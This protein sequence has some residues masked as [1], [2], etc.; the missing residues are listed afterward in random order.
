[1][2][3]IYCLLFFVLCSV[4]T[5]AQNNNPTTL[6]INFSA[7]TLDKAL[8]Q[9]KDRS[10]VNIAYD[11][12]GLDV[13]KINIA[14]RS[15]TNAPLTQVVEYLLRNTPFTY[16]QLA[17]GI[18]INR[19]EK[20]VPEKKEEKPT[21]LKG[22]VVDF[23]TSQPLPGATVRVVQ[24]DKAVLT[25]E[26]GFYE[27]RNLPAG[28]YTL[29]VSYVGY[30][31]TQITGVE[32]LNNRIVAFDI[33]MQ[34]GKV[35][36]TVEV[37][38][39]ARKVKAVTHSTDRQLLEEIRSSTGVVS[40][41]SNEFINKT[42]DRNGAEIVKRISGVTVVDDRFIVIRG[43]NERYNL[44]YL[45][46]NVAPSTE[47]FGKAFAYDLLPSSVIDKILVYKSPVADLV[48]D[49]GGA[50]LKVY[51]KNTMP[52]KHLDVG[53]QLGHRPGSTN[54][55]INSY[56]GG[57]YDFLGF[58]DGTRRLPAFARDDLHTNLN[59]NGLKQANMVNAF[60]STLDYGTK[61]SL[62]DVQ[63]FL[64]Y[65]N[66][67]KLGKKSR[68]YN[69][70]T[71]N[72]T[73]ETRS[74]TL[75]Q[76][77]G[78]TYAFG[79]DSAIGFNYG[80]LNR[81]K[82]NQQSVEIGK[83]N[84]LENITWKWND[85]N[86]I[87]LRNF[88]VNDGRNFTGITDSRLNAAKQMDSLLLRRTR[89][90]VLSFQQRTLYSGNLGGLHQFKRHL[91]SELE[92]NLGFTFN[93]QL[94]PDQRISRFA[95]IQG[96]PYI[97]LGSNTGAVED[98][99][100]GM[101]SRQFTVSQEKVYNGSID[102]VL[103]IDKHLSL[104]AGTYQM[105][106]LRDV[107]RRLFRVNR[108]GLQ[109]DDNGTTEG[110]PPG[111]IDGY[112]LSNQRLTH[113]TQGDLHAIWNPANFPDD[114]TGLRLYNITQP[115]D[116]YVASEQN[117]SAYLMG[118]WK[119]ANEKLI[120][121]AGLRVEY[122]RQKAA[123]AAKN[124]GQLM[125]SYA[126]HPLTSWLPSV[127]V[128]YLP[129]ANLVIRAGY[130][131]TMNR[132][133]FREI[134]AYNDYDFSNNELIYG[135]SEVVSAMIDNFDLRAEWYPQSQANNEVI[136]LGFFYK[137]IQH[138]IERLR[139][140]LTIP[141]AS[142]FTIISFGNADRARVYGIEGELRKNLSFINHP[143]FKRFSLVLNGAWI[144]SSTVQ[145]VR[146][147]YLRDTASGRPLQGQSPYIFNSALFYEHIGWG[148]KIGLIYNVSG[149]RLYAKSVFNRNS[150]IQPGNQEVTTRPDL[151]QL[152]V[153]LLDLA[154]TQRLIKS[155]QVKFVLQNI[156][157][158]P[159]RIIEDHNYNQRY[160]KEVP[161]KSLGGVDYFTGDNIYSSFKPGRFFQLQFT[162]SL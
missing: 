129:H 107:S 20:P 67:W 74:Y 143:L 146:N 52:V 28:K 21:G 83:I 23:E 43:M 82:S 64:N 1:M 18:L 150:N 6:S 158:R 15:F 149:P 125:L 122:D 116:S 113:F 38:S 9:L 55:T 154:I 33:K 69:L 71:V 79:A 144:K 137:G 61:H 10:P 103:H 156:L 92:W 96:S 124:E 45:N 63:L 62:P 66:M 4:I 8:E 140:E 22:R 108:G 35:L 84:V 105:Y 134:S 138:P 97:A 89:Q 77:S 117:N 133:E 56:N 121:N 114:N 31:E 51:T 47:L 27:I 81:I 93:Q 7:T 131:R 17:G 126:N 32:V 19:A 88:F 13:K 145:I 152:P 141:D 26:Q 68:L 130:G 102:Y 115:T 59:N 86:R 95:S 78:N 118:D 48:A 151:V 25:N 14:A 16:H 111:Y 98:Q 161:A 72:Y 136:N 34:A 75:S 153:H 135:S 41:I 157:D 147:G 119:T 57:K 159:S 37:S 85:Q 36:S 80:S 24:N 49:Y 44:T 12:T 76:Q 73:H 58:D 155:L 110:T 123:S 162:Y 3:G 65:Y 11:V 29:L 139:S 109:Q 120:L 53:I 100:P 91:A 2:P 87:M 142:N 50:A 128:S 46:G 99:L 101:I 106:K 148:T 90:I 40:G 160:D 5:Y 104:K 132:P 39:G 60:S 54:T 94:V 112:G 127:N 30:Q 42:A 70:T